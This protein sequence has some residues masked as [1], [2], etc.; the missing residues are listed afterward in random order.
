MERANRQ[1]LGFKDPDELRGKVAEFRE[2]IASGDKLQE[3]ED[4]LIFYRDI[5]WYCLKR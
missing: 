4:A 1:W 5:E 2:K 3:T